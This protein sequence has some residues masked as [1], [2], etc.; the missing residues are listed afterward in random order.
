[1]IGTA[2]CAQ[3]A[4]ADMPYLL[5]YC[6]PVLALTPAS[7][8]EEGLSEA[9]LLELR[10]SGAV[11]FEGG[12]VLSARGAHV[13]LSA[14]RLECLASGCDGVLVLQTEN[15]AEASRVTRIDGAA[16]LSIQHDAKDVRDCV[17]EGAVD[18]YGW[19][20]FRLVTTAEKITGMLG[21]AGRCG[22]WDTTLGLAST[23]LKAEIK[24]QPNTDPS[25]GTCW[26][27]ARWV[28]QTNSIYNSD[29]AVEISPSELR[30]RILREE[31]AE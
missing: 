3:S 27:A 11:P 20:E 17:S 29:I 12:T 15:S 1:M 4:N 8:A 24:T 16:M 7:D 10:A 5:I 19:D 26:N 30:R 14:S 6:G 9:A 21:Q 22:D 18:F 13:V 25:N 28:E 2:L 31:S 23:V